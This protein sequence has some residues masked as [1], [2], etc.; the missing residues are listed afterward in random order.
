MIL[1]SSKLAGTCQSRSTRIIELYNSYIKLII[2]TFPYASF[3]LH[4]Y[5]E[6]EGGKGIFVK[7]EMFGANFYLYSFL[8]SSYSVTL[9][10]SGKLK[11]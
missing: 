6:R 3:F 11:H 8:S 9:F 1:R 7:I 4:T 2:S 5:L 10:F